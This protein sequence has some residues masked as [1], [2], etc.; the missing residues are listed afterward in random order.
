MAKF[1]KDK[2][3][4]EIVDKVQAAIDSELISKDDISKDDTDRLAG[5]IQY[6][7]VKYITNRQEALDVLKVFDF[8][9]SRWQVLQDEIGGFNSLIDVALAN[10]WKYMQNEGALEYDYYDTEPVSDKKK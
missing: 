9:E 5:F 1:N 8:D 4:I 2:F 6:E 7:L 3:L 10:L